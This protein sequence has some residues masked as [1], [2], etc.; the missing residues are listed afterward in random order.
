MLQCALSATVDVISV[1]FRIN[2]L[3]AI[4]AKFIEKTF[5]DFWKRR[6]WNQFRKKRLMNTG[7]KKREML[8]FWKEISRSV[9]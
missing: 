5:T 7:L 6:D 3:S 4:D 8:S 2:D 9:C 1:T